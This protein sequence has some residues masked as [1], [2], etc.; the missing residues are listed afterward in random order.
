MMLINTCIV[1][2]LKFRVN[3]ICLTSILFRS[4]SSVV[5]LFDPCY[6]RASP[7]GAAFAVQQTSFVIEMVENEMSRVLV[8]GGGVLGATV[9]FRSAQA[10]ASVTLLDAGPLGHGASMVGYGVTFASNKNDLDYYQLN[11]AGMGEH[12]RLK[13][14]L[15]R[16]PWLHQVGSI[17]WELERDT[18]DYVGNSEP[19]SDRVARLRSWGY[20]IESLP[21]S[22]LR[23]FEPDIVPPSAVTEFTYFADEGYV[24]PVLYIGHLIGMAKDHGAE[25]RTHC[26]VTDFIREGDSITGVK[27]STGE[28]FF[29]DT[30][31][32]CTGRWTDE[33][34]KLAEIDFPMSP[35][36]GLTM[37]SKPVAA[38]LHTVVHDGGLTTL[39]P[40]GAGRVMIHNNDFDGM[41]DPQ[42][43]EDPTPE[44]QFALLERAA[45]VLPQLRGTEIETARVTVRPVPG[46]DHNSAVGPIEGLKGLYFVVT[47]SG[48]NLAPLLGRLA[49]TEILTGFQDPRL[50]NFR[51]DRLIE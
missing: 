8:I 33:V 39:R 43:P 25:I 19:L 17:H 9:A 24:D 46:G 32:S 37:I 35:W 14:E 40:D 13:N 38:R 49:S 51:P 20:K 5:Y 4:S 18:R 50:S 45:Q 41:V 12:I 29:A 30:V 42:K 2:L 15:G 6:D 16:A 31:V 23:H 34:A 36:I 27:T 21:I 7:F 3:S 47:H 26:A 10:G 22:E 48:I 11:L 28:T 44:L 1:G